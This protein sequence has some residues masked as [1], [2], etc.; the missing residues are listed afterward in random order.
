[1]IAAGVEP[2]AVAQLIVTIALG[3]V[4]QRALTGDADVRAHAAALAALGAG[5]PASGPQRD[6]T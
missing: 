4:A 3:F 1:M 6:P 5:A 2:G